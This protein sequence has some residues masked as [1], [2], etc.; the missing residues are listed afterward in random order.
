MWAPEEDTETGTDTETRGWTATTESCI[1]TFIWLWFESKFTISG[2]NW[3]NTFPTVTSEW[4]SSSC[5]FFSSGGWHRTKELRHQLT[6]IKYLISLQISIGMAGFVQSTLCHQTT[7]RLHKWRPVTVRIFVCS[8]LS[9]L[10][11]T[12]TYHQ[13][14]LI[15]A[16][17]RRELLRRWDLL[18]EGNLLEVKERSQ[19]R[20]G[21]AVDDWL[22]VQTKMRTK[23]PYI[24]PYTVCCLS[25]ASEASS[26]TPLWISLELYKAPL[27]SCKL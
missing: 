22:M 23:Y 1:E 3:P 5:S 16:V 14:H 21:S 12:V 9:H 8:L 27:P 10:T 24:Y 19:G 17:A 26:L 2:S 15:N 25:A 20:N 11:A 6:R 13:Q 7:K 18:E 4:S